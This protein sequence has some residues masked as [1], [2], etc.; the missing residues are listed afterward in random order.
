MPMNLFRV[1]LF[2]GL[3]THC[4]PTKQPLYRANDTL[5]VP[6]TPDSVAHLDWTTS[7][8]YTAL[9]R[10]ILH[11]LFVYETHSGQTK[12][13]SY[14]V[15][16]TRPSM[17]YKKWTLHLNKNIQW[18][19]GAPFKVQ[20][21]VE[22]YF[23][24]LEPN[25]LSPRAS[26]LF[27]IQGA[28]E[29]NQ[30]KITDPAKVGIKKNG[31]YSLTFTLKE[32]NVDFPHFLSNYHLT[33]WRKDLFEKYGKDWI[34]AKN[35]AV[36]GPYKPIEWKNKGSVHYIANPNYPGPDPKIKK[37]T[38]VL[39]QDSD[40]AI[41]LFKKGK[42]DISLGVSGSYK[43]SFLK[44]GEYFEFPGTAVV[45]LG[46][47]VKK[48]P[49][50]N[51]YLRKALAHAINKQDIVKAAGD[52]KKPLD[53]FLPDSLVGFKLNKKE[54]IFD[55]AKA[56]EYL[57]KSKYDTSKPLEIY[58]AGTWEKHVVQVESIQYQLK[59]NL[60]LKVNINNI[61]WKTY[62]AGLAK[63]Q[64]D[65]FRMF[66]EQNYQSPNATLKI[67]QSNSPRNY[68]QW[69]NLKYDQL[70]K[71]IAATPRRQQKD[72]II[73]ANQI[74][75]DEVP[76]IPLYSSNRAYLIDKRVQGFEHSPYNHCQYHFVS[77]KE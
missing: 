8:E 64:Y 63:S 25:N 24:I 72:F 43:K 4:Q 10:P 23:R 17:N 66:T 9:L 60:G 2:V 34:L 37:L 48:K 30:G 26:L 62:L 45:Y 19:D 28:E 65:S 71:K 77:F 54:L 16:K 74:L 59:K 42:L 39:V 15:K 18:S 11:P 53:Y 27:L 69:S 41:N 22:T 12:L 40:T 7:H 73:R 75:L 51:L 68:T 56:K 13:K 21:V 49:F 5:W 31:D 1:I 20:Q 3:L 36:L 6:S 38:S 58:M 67:L 33:P 57:E 55:I 52:G 44:R 47:H 70:I 29:F 61:E 35:L 76:I 46:F 50:N 32:S 14:L